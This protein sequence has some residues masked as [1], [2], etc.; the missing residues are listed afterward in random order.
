MQKPVMYMYPQDWKS[1]STLRNVFAATPVLGLA[2]EGLWFRL[3]LEIH[4]SPRAGYLLK[5]NGLAPSLAEIAA[6]VNRPVELVKHLIEELDRE[7]VFSRDDAGTIY[8][9]KMVKQ[10]EKAERMRKIAEARW[11]EA[12]TKEI[13][14]PPTTPHA[15]RDAMRTALRNA[16]PNG[17]GNGSYSEEEG[18]QREEALVPVLL[19]P[20]VGGEPWP[21]F[22]AKVVEYQAV[23]QG[24]DVLAEV[25]KA[26]QWCV[27]NPTRRK[28]KRGMLRFLF[29][30]LER[31]QNSAHAWG[32]RWPDV[33]HTT[34]PARRHEKPPRPPSNPVRLSGDQLTRVLE[35]HGAGAVA[36][37]L[38]QAAARDRVVK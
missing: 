34:V 38:R 13:L 16:S 22:Q 21:L 14:N 15:L 26:Y 7:H 20:V 17:N 3:C 29:G 37:A 24:I 27:D 1:E 6:W 25:K 10:A 31:A 5:E 8:S 36:A 18:V 28:T 19:F 33:V 30:W 2:A 23:F 32:G 35:E 12:P 9:R 4:A 11:S